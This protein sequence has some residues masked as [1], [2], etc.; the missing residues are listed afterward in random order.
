MGRD[1][2]GQTALAVLVYCDG[3]GGRRGRGLCGGL[4]PERGPERAA[5]GGGGGRSYL[6]Y[7]AE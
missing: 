7:G 1:V 3:D 2:S 5:G 4:G 6:N